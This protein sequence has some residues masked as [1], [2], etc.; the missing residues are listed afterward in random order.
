MA[1][2][3]SAHECVVLTLT[4]HDETRR[5]TTH[6]L[7]SSG[8]LNCV[9]AYLLARKLGPGHCVVTFLCDSGARYASKIYNPAWLKEK[10]I[11]IGPAED[12]SFLRHIE[13]VNGV[14]PLESATSR[15][16]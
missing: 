1:T 11:T 5:S 16:S 4:R 2:G 10:N 12:L 6:V 9:A 15:T 3:P 8:A 13:E 7:G 14:P